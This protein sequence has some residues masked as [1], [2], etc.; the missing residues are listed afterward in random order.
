MILNLK[1]QLNILYERMSVYSNLPRSFVLLAS[2]VFIIFSCKKE[3]PQPNNGLKNCDCAH[4]VN[5]NFSIEEIASVVNQDQYLT[6]TDTIYAG[7]NVRFY[8]KEDSA[9]YTWY[10][11]SEVLTTREVKRYFSSAYAGIT[12][13][14]SLVVKKKPNSICFPN[15]DGYDSISKS[16]Y[17]VP[18]LQ[19]PQFYQDTN[20]RI[21]GNYRVKSEFDSDSLDII[22]DL[23]TFYPGVLSSNNLI[24]SGLKEDTLLAGS[25]FG[26]NYK[27]IWLNLIYWWP[28]GSG[29]YLNTSNVAFSENSIVLSLFTTGSTNCKTTIYKGRKL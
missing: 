24:I 8:A 20:F 10:I 3:Q 28:N 16:F 21:E 26:I 4:Q 27:K 18:E 13:P 5:A 17:I 12:I 1:P 7:K 23:E 6:E 2:F 11:G 19:F 22:L 15:D 14:I 9:E 25:P 29:C